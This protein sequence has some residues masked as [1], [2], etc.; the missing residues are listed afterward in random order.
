MSD[1]FRHDQGHWQR[2]ELPSRGIWNHLFAA[3]QTWPESPQFGRAAHDS[4]I[5]A[6][7][8]TKILPGLPRG[9]PLWSGSGFVSAVG[10]GEIEA[11]RGFRAYLSKAAT[12]LLS[13]VIVQGSTRSFDLYRLRGS[14][15]GEGNAIGTQPCWGSGP[16][17]PADCGWIDASEWSASR[18]KICRLFGPNYTRRLCF[19]GLPTLVEAGSSPKT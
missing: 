12:E 1:E 16:L 2:H 3:C 10:R 6:N 15:R 4:R 19:E 17:Q 7:P 5:L 9:V 14:F 11:G 18:Q 8:A 13:V